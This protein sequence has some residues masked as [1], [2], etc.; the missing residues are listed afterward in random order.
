MCNTYALLSTN[1]PGAS[2]PSVMNILHNLV[3]IT[4][5]TKRPSF[6]EVVVYYY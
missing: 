6:A 5:G 1:V 4:F 2:R 3:I